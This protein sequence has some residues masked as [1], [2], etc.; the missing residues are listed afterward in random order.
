MIWKGIIGEIMSHRD[1]YID[2]VRNT[3]WS[4]RTPDWQVQAPEFKTKS[5]E[6]K[7][8]K[9]IPLVLLKKVALF[10]FWKKYVLFY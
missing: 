5:A 10:F 7:S 9:R 8:F 3:G 2:Q 6:A 1:S 4:G